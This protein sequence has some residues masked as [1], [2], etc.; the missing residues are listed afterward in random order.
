M[1]TSRTKKQLLAFVFITLIG[2]SYVGARYARLD[3]LVYDSTY[4]VNAQFKESGGIFTGAEVTYRGVGVGQV[5][6]MKLTKEG[7]TVV[8]AIDKGEDKIPADAIALVG[9]K[10]AVG[11]QYV[12]LQPKSDG[13]PYLKDNSVIKQVS[14]QIPVS[15]T[16]ILTN[17]DGL[18]RS[19]PEG[20]LRTVVSELGDA[21]KDT[22]DD[23]GQII[24][25]S[26]DFIQAAN[27]NFDVTTALIKDG[28]TVLTTQALKGSAIKSFAKDLSLF[29]GVL[30]D[31]DA[32][33][34]ALIDNG[35][36]TANEL[37][38]FLQ[39]NQVDLGSLINN[40]VTTGNIIV[41]HLPGIRQVLV[42]YPYMVAGGFTVAA[43]N[44]EGVNA[45]FGLVLTQTPGLCAKGY[46]PKERRTP[47][48][49]EDKAMDEDAA[50]TDMSGKLVPRGAQFA[51]RTATGFDSP[52]ATYDLAKGTT[53]W[54]DQASATAG[55]SP[56]AG[57]TV[58]NTLLLQPLT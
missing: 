37:R 35:S 1:I 13:G 46:D 26:N 22:G 52:V 29:T 23:L 55:G 38:T 31:N 19:V 51:P 56:V 5:E 15:T 14:T 57:E 47:L 58:W 34:R 44:S 54:N 30:A 53:S 18:V 49:T 16:E 20:S 32:S 27:D 7:V 6:D 41:K 40:L 21:F 11:E 48:Q 9:N 36:A 17:L 39:Q 43:K 28:K 10:S 33:L 42:L 24:D 4:Q 25:T 12:E 8:L 50:C 3:R 45:R 2:V